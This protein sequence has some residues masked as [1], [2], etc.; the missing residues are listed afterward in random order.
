MLTLSRF[1][2]FVFIPTPICFL[3]KHLNLFSRN[4]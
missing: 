2:Q 1:K 4:H 3:F